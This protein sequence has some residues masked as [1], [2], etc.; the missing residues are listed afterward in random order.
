M[1]EITSTN[2]GHK[3][4]RPSFIKRS[5]RVDLTP[6]VDLGFILVTFFV[7]TSALS[8]NKVMDIMYPN[9]KTRGQDEICNSCVLTVL[10]TKDDELW[11][12]EGKEETASYKQTSYKDLRKLIVGKKKKVKQLRGADQFVLIIRP[13]Q[14]SQYHKLVD[15]M[16]E[17]VISA[18][19]R[20]YIDE[21][22]KSEV[23]RFE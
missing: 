11:Y 9:D 12:Y 15:I 19:A 5:T 10:P 20:Y 6:M 22:S 16:D 8:E 4:G 23:R 13:L 3:K 2:S 14:T 7:F 21:P 17:C 18:V 1:A